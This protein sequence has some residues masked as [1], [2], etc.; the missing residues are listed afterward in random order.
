MERGVVVRGPARWWRWA[1]PLAATAIIL[2]GINLVQSPTEPVGPV[3]RGDHQT[4]E[5]LSPVGE[6][7]IIPTQFSKMPSLS[8]SFSV[9]A[10][11]TIS[12]LVSASSEVAV[13]SLANAAV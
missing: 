7:A 5:L 13:V 11:I 2:V 8:A 12:T 1:A 9:A 10:S 4:V 3:M 6:V